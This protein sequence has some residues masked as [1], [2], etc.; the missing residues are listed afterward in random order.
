VRFGVN[1]GCHKGREE[2]EKKTKR[3]R[4]DGGADGALNPLVGEIECEFWKGAKRKRG[5]GIS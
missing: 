1:I 5:K 3:F 2:N 4:E